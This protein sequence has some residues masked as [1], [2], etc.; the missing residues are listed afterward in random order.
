MNGTL[1]TGFAVGGFFSVDIGVDPANSGFQDLKILPN[2]R[3]LASRGIANIVPGPSFV[4]FHLIMLDAQGS[5][6]LGFGH[7][8]QYTGGTITNPS[9]STISLQLL[10]S[11]KIFVAFG[12]RIAVLNAN[13]I[14]GN[15]LPFEGSHS[16]MSPDGRI[17]ANGYANGTG[18]TRLYSE[19]SIIGMTNLSGKPY[20][21]QNGKILLFETASGSGVLTITRLNLITSQGTRLADFDRDDKTD[22][23]YIRQGTRQF[24]ASFSGGRTISKVNTNLNPKIVPELIEYPNQ[25]PPPSSASPRRDLLVIATR[26]LN[27]MPGG[28]VFPARYQVTSYGGTAFASFNW[29]LPDDIPVGGDFNGDGQVDLTM[30]RPSDGIWYSARSDNGNPRYFQWGTVGDKPVPADYDYDGITDYAIYRPS[31]GSWW[32][33]RS[34]DNG[35]FVF[36][37]GVSSDIPLTGDFDGDGHADFTVFRPSEGIWYQYLTSEGFRGYRWGI[38]TDVPVPGDYD[39]DGRHDVAVFRDGIWYLLQSSDGF[40]AIQFGSTGDTPVSVRYDE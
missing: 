31:T 13:G 3:I 40:R 21:Q 17:L 35:T 30:F 9:L 5:I 4:G 8:G 19:T 27:I 24:F 7:N 39:G 10:P 33:H 22:F 25:L 11:G 32:V 38:S 28:G 34:S 15:F 23:A 16:D 18:M 2:G 6:Y 37:W 26:G 36:R 14:G 1:D 12:P 20:F 29:G